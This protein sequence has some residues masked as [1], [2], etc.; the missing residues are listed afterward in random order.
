MPA[1]FVQILR[2]WPRWPQVQECGR[3]SYHH[4]CPDGI[5][6]SGAGLARGG[7]GL[8][9]SSVL[10]QGLTA[11]PSSSSLSRAVTGAR[12]RGSPQGPIPI[13][14]AV[15]ICLLH[16]TRPTPGTSILSFTV[17]S[18]DLSTHLR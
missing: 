15:H 17:T 13:L 10:S 2:E 7:L 4:G 3:S 5:D 14:L 18:L 16:S 11:G 6:K 8:G 9:A 12:H 1:V